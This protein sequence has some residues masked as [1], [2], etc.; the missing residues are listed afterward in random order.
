MESRIKSLYQRTPGG[1]TVTTLANPGD[2]AIHLVFEGDPSASALSLDRFEDKLVRRLR[3]WVY[4]RR[5]ESLEA[6]VGAL[7]KETGLTVACAESCTGGLLGHRLTNVP[8]SSSYF[9]ESAVAYAD[10][11]KKKRLGVPASLLARHGAVSEQVARAMAAGIKKT[12]GSDFGLAIT[13]I[14]GPSGGTAAKPVGLVFTALAG[15]RGVIAEENLFWG[16]RDLVKFQSSQKAL[17]MLRKEL[18]KGR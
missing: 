14:A 5:G 1:I 17:N 8:G 2:L 18:I 15:P 10:A 13:G 6:V 11:A 12:S 9:L 3:P 7:L 4:S 16:G